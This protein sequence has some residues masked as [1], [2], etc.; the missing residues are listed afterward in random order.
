M[1]GF[2]PDDAS[3][4]RLPPPVMSAPRRGGHSIEPVTAADLQELLGLMRAY[5]EFYETAPGDDALLGLARALLADPQA[6]GL[7]LI[8]RGESSAAVGFATVLWSWDTTVAGRVGIMHD[9]YVAPPARGRGLAQELIDACVQRAARRGAVALD[10]ETAPEN[11]R[12]QAVYDGVGAVR[13]PWI[14]YRLE[15]DG[16]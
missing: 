9:L 16:P 7:Q 5:C 4:E 2:G 10:W 15:I 14:T 1:L 13:T 6:E 8:A 11:L 3:N 12:A